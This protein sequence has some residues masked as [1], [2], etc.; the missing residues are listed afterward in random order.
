MVDVTTQPEF[1]ELANGFIDQAYEYFVN[2]GL[3]PDYEV[4]LVPNAGRIEEGRP[5]VNEDLKKVTGPA[6]EKCFGN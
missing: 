5:I 3:K 4:R 1:E 6:S 2:A